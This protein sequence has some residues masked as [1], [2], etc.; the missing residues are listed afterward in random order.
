MSCKA[1]Q[2]GNEG[3]LSIETPRG[4]YRRRGKSRKKCAIRELK[5]RNWL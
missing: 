1:T 2:T 4:S 5:E 3:K